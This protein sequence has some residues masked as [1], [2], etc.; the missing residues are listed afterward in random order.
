V[1]PNYFVL[2]LKDA[3]NSPALSILFWID[4]GSKL[5]SAQLGTLQQAAVPHICLKRE[6]QARLHLQAGDQVTLEAQNCPR[7]LLLP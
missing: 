7:V 2:I 3:K 1:P 6:C 4:N 5:L